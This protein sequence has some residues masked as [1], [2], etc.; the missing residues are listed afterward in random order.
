M[1]IAMGF[2]VYAAIDMLTDYTIAN[3]TST[4]F[5][6]DLTILASHYILPKAP[7]AA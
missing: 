7:F 4:D 6:E 1:L 3:W 2:D 5:V